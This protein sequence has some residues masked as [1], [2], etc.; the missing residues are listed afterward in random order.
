MP[1][2]NL[3]QDDTAV[4]KYR[5]AAVSRSTGISV[6]T[7]RVWELR[8]GAVQPTRSATNNRLY[9]R[10][11]IERLALLKSAVDE[12]H[13][14]GTIAALGNQQIAAR[15]RGAAPLPPAIT[16][17]CRV[18]VVGAHLPSILSAAWDGRADI[19]VAN[20]FASLKNLESETVTGV[21]A[22]VVEAPALKPELVAVLRKLR[23][24]TGARVIVIVYAFAS[25]KTLARLDQ[26]NIIALSDP[27]DPLQI[28]RICQLSLSAGVPP[29]PDMAR[30]FIQPAKP[31]RYSDSYL[32]T[33]SH[34]PTAVTC[35]CPSH[36]ATLVM[37]MTTFERYSLDCESLNAADANVHTLL[38]SAAGRCREILEIALQRVVEHEGITPQEVQISK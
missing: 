35:G 7:I 38:Y 32:M 30:Q 2:A 21:A 4:G 6:A 31:A 10:G 24:T 20:S 27:V 25:T 11:D 29:K 15:V 14:I 8:Y 9:S 5:I 37:R 22:L 33:L 16:E 3:V 12:G 13:A 36:L 1:N 34:L 17:V 28:A 18:V 26:A 19:D 23:S